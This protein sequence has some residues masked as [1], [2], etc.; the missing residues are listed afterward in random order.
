MPLTTFLAWWLGSFLAVFGIYE[1]NQHHYVKAPH[2]KMC[3]ARGDKSAHKMT[4]HECEEWLQ[5]PCIGLK[6]C[7]EC[8]R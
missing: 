6:D 7:S 8:W 2:F 4:Q 1:N 3:A 5:R